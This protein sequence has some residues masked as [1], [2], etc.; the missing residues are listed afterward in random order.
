MFK[1]RP[2]YSSRYRLLAYA[3][4]QFWW[5]SWWNIPIWKLSKVSSFDFILWVWIS[6]VLSPFQNNFWSIYIFFEFHYHNGVYF[7][8]KEYILV[9]QHKLSR[10]GW[11]LCT[12]IDIRIFWYMQ[13]SSCN[14]YQLQVYMFR[15]SFSYCT[16]SSL[17]IF[18][19][20]TWSC[21]DHNTRCTITVTIYIVYRLC[22]MHQ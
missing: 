2:A 12:F 22:I 8:S 19:V 17:Y 6:N 11:V 15:D 14:L 18:I 20:T 21:S 5:R 3:S 1:L 10:L 16:A 4:L 9:S 13:V 7:L